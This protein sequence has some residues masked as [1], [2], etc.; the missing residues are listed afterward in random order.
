MCLLFIP[1][2]L[3]TAALEEDA[4]TKY[5]AGA[6]LRGNWFSTIGINKRRRHCWDLLVRHLGPGS[7][8]AHLRRC[9]VVFTGQG[10]HRPASPVV[11]DCDA[12]C[13]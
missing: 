2:K 10:S 11:G 7:E 6:D 1:D 3:W 12:D 9:A 4:T 8:V 5:T 13:S